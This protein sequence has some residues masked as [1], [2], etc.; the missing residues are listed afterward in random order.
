MKKIMFLVFLFV[1][2][3]VYGIFADVGVNIS[4]TIER[5]D[6]MSGAEEYVG[7]ITV[8][9]ISDEGEKVILV[10]DSLFPVFFERNNFILESGESEDVGIFVYVPIGYDGDTSFRVDVKVI[11]GNVYASASEFFVLDVTGK[12]LSADEIR[13]VK[14]EFNDMKNELQEKEDEVDFYSSQVRMYKTQCGMY[15][16]RFYISLCFSLILM[17]VVGLLLRKIFKCEEVSNVYEEDV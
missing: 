9:N 10:S 13:K 4:K 6:I 16:N 5:D 3:F 15:K 12:G 8:N 14:E 17:F 1:F 11:S 7:Y 2:C